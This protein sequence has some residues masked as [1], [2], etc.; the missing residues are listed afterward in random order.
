MKSN[1]K[2]NLL[3]GFSASLI[4]LI[5][6][7]AASFISIQ[8]LLKSSNLV[9]HTNTVIIEL[10][11]IH[12]AM[13]DAETGQRGFLLTGEEE[14]LK[15]FEDARQRA[16][17][18]FDN[19]RRLTADNADQQTS[20]TALKRMLEE[21]FHYL[22]ISINAKRLAQPI[23]P[24]NLRQGRIRMDGVRELVATMQQR[25]RELLA[26]RTETMDT[27]AMYTPPLIIIAAL[28]ALVITLMF[29][30]RV[31]GD[32]EERLKLQLEL[33]RKDE[34]ITNRIAIIR[35]LSETIAQGN[36]EVRVNDRESDALGNVAGSLNKMAESLQ[37]SFSLL[38]DK[39]W[40]QTGLATL[41]DRMI[42]DKDIDLLTQQIIEHLATYTNSSV[43][44]LYILEGNELHFSSG[45]AYL[46]PKQRERIKISD[47][48]LGQC[49]ATGKAI[50]LKDIPAESIIVNHATGQIKPREIIAVPVFD[51]YTIKGAVELATLESYNQKHLDFF[52]ASA[53]NIGI[54]ITTAQNKRKLKELLEE[55]QAQAEELK[56]QHAELENLNSEL[57]VQAEKLQASEE[58]LKVQQEELKQANQEL[59]ERSRL[60][61]EKNQLIT[62]RNLDIQAKADQLAQSTKY[63]SEFLANMS[64]ELRTPLNS[65]LL[66]SRLMSENQEQ[67]L[68]PEQ[69]EYAKVIRSSGNGLLALIDEI[70]DLSKI[71]AGKMKLEYQVVSL[72]EIAAD[73]SGLFSPVAKEKNIDFRTDIGND[74]PE[75]VETDKL[76]LEQIVRN[77]LSNALKFTSKGFVSLSIY[78]DSD[79]PE[80]VKI[81]VQDTGIGIPKDKQG[82]V[83]EAFQQADG[84]TRR[85]FGG[86]GLGLSISRELIKLLGGEITLRSEVDR[87]SEFEI[88]IPIN[89][90]ATK[91]PVESLMPTASPAPLQLSRENGKH[92]LRKQY[93]STVIPESIPDDR[94]IIAEGDKSILIIEDD[95][96]FAKS[97]LDF[98]RKKGYKGIVT[99]R[100]DEGI[101]L[102][103]QFS[104]LGILLDIQ[105]PV[106]SGWE[107]MEELK[108]TPETRHIPVHIMSSHQVKSE[109]LLQGAVDFINKPFAFDQMQEVFK[110]IE[111]VL[112]HHPKKVLIVEENARHAK[113]L[114]YFL[115]T[116]EVNLEIK[117]DVTDAISSL[118][119]KNVDCVILDMGIP[120]KKSYDTLDT[121]KKTPGLENLPIIIFT[122]KSLSQ[123]E[124]MKIKQ[125]ADSIVIKT[126][127]SYKRIIDEVSLFLHLMEKDKK[128]EAATTRYPKLGALDEVLKDKTVLVADDDMRNIFSLTKALEMYKM[129][130]IAAVDGK[131]ALT[132]LKENKSIDIVLMDMMMPEMDGYESTAAIRKENQFKNLPIIA[133][134]AKA[135]MGDREKCINAGASDYITKPVDIDQ[136]LS[137]LRVW[138]YEST[139]R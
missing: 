79:R 52:N 16:I 59:E 80:F 53:A 107:V 124:E 82:V 32:F 77:L 64:H 121:V 38:S 42:G 118:K 11:A 34:E 4:I 63:K 94:N 17:R 128:E 134:T 93:I 19:A 103:K 39:E 3:V 2:R 108:G 28:L 65:I 88:S 139:K 37:Y 70:L 102:A 5:I 29:Y 21:R 123:T 97:L 35:S 132:K 92:D 25:E 20:L 31:K 90:H 135:M 14:Y 87:G 47:G 44:A 27:F 9:N 54:T 6:S 138:L 41:N 49:I 96:N 78:R 50:V 8:N 86:T 101:D 115:E 26:A 89:K 55:T 109:S 71:E 85:K 66:L 117:N 104:P 57:E 58:E 62:E 72:R 83:F 23:I 73:M 91:K 7:S 1:F 67:N 116:F 48:M 51:G 127:H 130:V 112:A 45:F 114:A 56:A 36:Y 129:N 46:P 119:D 133:V 125:Y 84:S 111:Y 106:K 15:P 30:L 43:G 136:L 69:I 10:N 24:E 137:L 75:V 74:V 18:H 13:V 100:G 113:A 81:Q 61:E 33:Q 22:D 76:R 105:L 99:V 60:L 98:S 12:A 95:V 122:G 120:D 110:K 126:A 40:H 131:D 68:T